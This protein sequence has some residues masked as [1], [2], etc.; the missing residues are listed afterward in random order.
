MKLTKILALTGL[1][2]VP[3]AAYALTVVLPHEAPAH[4][5]GHYSGALPSPSPLAGASI[6]GS[7]ADASNAPAITAEPKR[8]W[9]EAAERART[10]AVDGATS[11]TAFFDSD[12]GASTPGTTTPAT[13]STPI[14]P[15]EPVDPVP[16]HTESSDEHFKDTSTHTPTSDT[17]AVN[18]DTHHENTD[19]HLENTDTHKQNTDTHFANTDDHTVNTDKHTV[20]TDTHYKNTDDHTRNTD[21]HSNNTDTHKNNTDSHTTNTDTHTNNTNTHFNNTDDHSRSSTTHK[22]NSDVHN[23]TSKTHA[24]NS[25]NHYTGSD[26]HTTNSDVHS[27]GSDTHTSSSK[28]HNSGSDDHYTSS[29]SHMNSSDTHYD[30][31][32]QHDVNVSLGHGASSI[33]HGPA[34]GSHDGISS[35]HNSV[36]TTHTGTS[37]EGGGGGGNTGPCESCQNGCSPNTGESEVNGQ[38]IQTLVVCVGG[39]ADFELLHRIVTHNT[40]RPRDLYGKLRFNRVDGTDGIIALK[41]GGAPV[42][43]GADVQVIEPG[44][45]G[46]GVHDW[47][48]GIKTMTVEG[49]QPGMIQLEAV[50]DPDPE[51]PEGDGGP[52]LKARVTIHVVKVEML[53]IDF[54]SDHNL[55][56]D[57]ATSWT[58]EGA[59]FTGAEWTNTGTNHPIS[60]TKDIAPTATF[61][62]KV[63]PATAPNFTLTL[64]GD[65]SIDSFKY[66]KEQ[67]LAGGTTDVSITA[68]GKLPNKVCIEEHTI[69]WKYKVT[70]NGSTSECTLPNSG[71]HKA[72]VTLATPIT[73]TTP[74][75]TPNKPTVKR[76][77]AVC[78]WADGAT[79]D[80]Q[81]GDKIAAYCLANDPPAFYLYGIVPLG[82]PFWIVMDGG[83]YQCVDLAYFMQ[84]ACGQVGTPGEIGFCYATTDAT[85]YSTSDTAHETRVRTIGTTTY[86]EILGFYASAFNSWESV[87][88]VAGV[89]YAVEF[90]KN[91][92][93]MEIVKQ[94]VCPNTVPGANYQAWSYWS[95]GSWNPDTANA[96][97]PVPWPGGCN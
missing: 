68:N 34:S 91:T 12:V 78:T 9:W 76:M 36:S 16:V 88:K 97:Y 11:T 65:G 35:T 32:D 94:F 75:V 44:H 79:S 96:P 48:Y 24:T 25:D 66:H 67:V 62:M 13:T 39:R 26:T 83:A 29:D 95:L 72:F 82:G 22:T 59:A 84:A 80:L 71:P 17:H 52:T 87:I 93:S 5:G 46:C 30:N 81:V 43:L 51:T 90:D 28:V 3:V 64:D 63:T 54:T 8:K 18:T 57:E 77:Q 4:F 6:P 89:L 50:V 60:H 42:A 15:V 40:G 14:G 21:T 61:K 73:A 85:N 19:T 74:Y 1:S 31:S 70:A 49:L 92:S 55:L 56:R 10:T 69:V 33:T 7:V 41:D 53:S 58:A 45:S 20:N 23:S 47:H 38:A 37:T 86:D 27:N 2:F